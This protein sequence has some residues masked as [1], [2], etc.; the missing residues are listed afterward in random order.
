METKGLTMKYKHKETKKV[1]D[2][3]IELYENIPVEELYHEATNQNYKIVEVMDS[4]CIIR[5]EITKYEV[6]IT[7]SKYR[8]ISNK[9]WFE[10]TYER[11]V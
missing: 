3:D 8:F 6:L 1:F 9:E 5:R 4:G 2:F 10:N 7:Y 11:L